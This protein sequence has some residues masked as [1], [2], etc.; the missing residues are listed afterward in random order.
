[1]RDSE[2]E[3]SQPRKG[4]KSSKKSMRA[5]PAIEILRRFAPL[6]LF[7]GRSS[8]WYN[9][10]VERNGMPKVTM[11]PRIAEAA[12]T[13]EYRLKLVFTDGTQ[14]EVNLQDWVVGQGGV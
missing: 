14:G 7:R 2:N 9:S 4:S 13:R 8:L 11:F 10:R 3:E 5:A 1:M 6:E 12:P